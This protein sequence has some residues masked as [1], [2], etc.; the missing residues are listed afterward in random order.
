MQDNSTPRSIFED[1]L[2]IAGRQALAFIVCAAAGASYGS[3]WAW[4]LGA[5][6]VGMSVVPA[7]YFRDLWADSL[8]RRAI[9]AGL[10]QIIVTGAVVSLLAFAL[11]GWA[12]SLMEQN[13]AVVAVSAYGVIASAAIQSICAGIMLACLIHGLGLPEFLDE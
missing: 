4:L 7:G 8:N 10:V 1:T 3:V 12:A 6:G 9:T 13:Q 11:L 5:I 2:A